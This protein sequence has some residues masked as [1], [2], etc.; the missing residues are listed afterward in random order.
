VEYLPVRY[1]PD[2]GEVW[3]LVRAPEQDALVDDFL[4]AVREV[5][6]PGE[7]AAL[8][9]ALSADE[10]TALLTYGRRRL[11]DRG[12][13]RSGA[14]DVFH[15][16]DP[17]RADLSRDE[18]VLTARLVLRYTSHAEQMRAP[19]GAVETAAALVP[20]ARQD[21]PGGP[22]HRLVE[23]D[24][25]RRLIY[26][27][28]PRA[29]LPLGQSGLVIDLAELVE[30]KGYRV[31][32]ITLVDDGP[33]L[34]AEAAVTGDAALFEFLRSG[35]CSAV[36]AGPRPGG[37]PGR[38]DAHLIMSGMTEGAAEVAAKATALYSGR[39]AVHTR[40]VNPRFLLIFVSDGPDPLDGYRFLI[41]ALLRESNG[42]PVRSARW[43]PEP[44]PPTDDHHSML[45]MD[46]RY[47]DDQPVH[48]WWL[49]GPPAHGSHPDPEGAWQALTGL[50]DPFGG[51]GMSGQSYHGP[52]TAEV[53]G[54]WRGTWVER[55]FGRR[56]EAG[57][58]RWERL[59][60]FLQP[61][62]SPAGPAP[63]PGDHDEG[64]RT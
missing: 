58:A 59:R 7:L 2:A 22:A 13:F 28:N 42:V 9:A 12:A 56:H 32:S 38:L 15:L 24:G 54:F 34:L 10:V 44:E 11:I 16:I 8:R 39:G 46:V 4:T 26:D 40:V 36:R 50:D 48:R 25:Q 57:A 30:S 1:P 37:R 20:S 18:I 60:P 35:W 53:R 29:H 51:Y 61:G 17:D 14:L 3:K 45:V 33:E 27:L 31:E 64:D 63:G 23:T 43:Y 5:T 49:A 6:D 62:G 55:G 21:V 41:R 19:A 52:E 47:G